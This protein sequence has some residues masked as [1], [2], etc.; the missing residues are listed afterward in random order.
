[1]KVTPHFS[2]EEFA[3]RDGTPYPERWVAS[4]LHLL[5]EQ[6]ELVR[7]ELGDIAIEITS[8]Y[9]TPSY[10]RRIGGALKSQHM[11]GR[12]ADIVVP[13]VSPARVHAA[14]LGM[15]QDGRLAIGGLGRYPRFTHCDVRVA[16]RLIRWTG[17]RDGN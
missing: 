5:C 4:R 1:M 11:E 12:A 15:Y 8:G 3:C 9:R 17:S 10:N 7:S 13:G 14:I 6:L 2:R 16:D